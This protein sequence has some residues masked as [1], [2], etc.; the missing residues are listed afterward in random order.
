MKLGKLPPIEDSRDLR[1][2]SYLTTLPSPPAIFGFGGLYPDWGTLGNDKYGD[3]VFAGA[4]HET[5]L[6]NKV[7][8]GHDVLIGAADALSDYS[9]VTGFDPKDPN[10]DQ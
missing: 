8:G 10:T 5:M 9:A 4:D 1:L 7:R 3:C 6:W 2:T